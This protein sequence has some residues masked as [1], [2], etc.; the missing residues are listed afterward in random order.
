V[1]EDDF[2][3]FVAL[4]PD[5]FLLGVLAFGS[6]DGAV[7]VGA[8][9][10]FDKGGGEPALVPVPRGALGLPV[11]VAPESSVDVDSCKAS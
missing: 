4:A 1:L 7:R 9:G 11:G 10:R 8:A 5:L 3:F 6:F 2:F